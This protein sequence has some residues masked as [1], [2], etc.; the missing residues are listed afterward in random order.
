MLVELVQC[1]LR[2]GI[3]LELDLDPHPRAVR[4][5]GEV[6]D[7]G[8]DLVVDEVGDLLD[9]A[10]IANLLHAVRQLGDDDRGLAAAQLLDV[11][12]SPHDDPAAS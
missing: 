12:A 10:D 9:H 8:Q 2:D 7:L 6:R 1:H 3:P 5:V 4:V 11:C